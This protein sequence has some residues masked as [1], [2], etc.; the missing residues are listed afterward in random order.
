MKYLIILLFVTPLFVKS[1]DTLSINGLCN[2][3]KVYRQTD[4][5]IKYTAGSNEFINFINVNIEIP[6]KYKKNKG[7]ITLEMIVNCEGKMISSKLISGVNAW[8][9]AEVLAVLRQAKK[10][11]PA[12]IKEENVDAYRTIRI[13]FNGKKF[14]LK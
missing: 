6:A 5:E 14:K 3:K 7:L 1:Q 4:V 2:N 13:H 12:K 11:Y 10:W 8:I 9:D